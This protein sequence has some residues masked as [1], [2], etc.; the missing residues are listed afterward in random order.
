MMLGV[1]VLADRDLAHVDVQ[2]LLAAADVGQLHIDLAVETARTQQGGVQDV[3]PVGGRDHDHA[4]VGLEAVHLDQHLVQGL[5]ALVVAAAQAGAT[6][7]ADG[8]DFIDED[9]A[10]RVLLGVL[11]HVAH[12]GRAH[13]DEHF[14]E[15]GAGNR[16]ERHL[17]FAG[18]ALGQQRLAGAGG[19]DQQQAARD[20]P[21]QLL[22]FLRVLQEVDDFLDFFFRFVA[23]CNV[24]E[25]HLVV[26]LVEHARL[27]LAEAEGAALAAALHLAHEVDPDPDQQQHRA[28]AD[29]QGHEQGAFLARLDVE[30]DVVVDQ[31][32][33]QAAVEIGRRGADLAVLSGDG[34]DL[35]AALAFL[36]DGV[37]DAL[38]AHFLQEVGI[39]HHRRAGRAT[40]IELL[41]NGKQH[42]GDD[43]PD[44]NFG[45]PLIVQ[46]CLRK[47]YL[48]SC[49]PF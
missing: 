1:D 37:L 26:V 16:E 46:L 6:L 40:R 41:E 8:V 19:A 44:G 21:A 33:D 4:Q 35:G 5:L 15:V 42:E 45:K 11:E 20:A 2:D 29:Q 27:A 23:A 48:S 10:R 38:A 47:E 49:C 39:A 7:A 31:V 36:D 28:P 12:A 13:A 24:G 43:Q 14:D 18:N 34:D 9:D 30:L 32:A 22:E 25:G 3:R 17:G